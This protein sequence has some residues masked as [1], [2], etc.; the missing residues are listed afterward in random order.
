MNVRFTS[1]PTMAIP[2][3]HS[4]PLP[5]GLSD[6]KEIIVDGVAG[7][8]EGFSINLCDGPDLNSQTA[9]HFNPRFN[10][11]EVVRTHNAGGWGAEEKQGAF[12]F[13]RGSG[14]QVKIVVKDHAY[15]V[16][17]NNS[18]FCDFNHRVPKE[19]V[20][21]VFVTG[22]TSLSRVSFADQYAPVINNPPVPFTTA[23]P[24]G[25]YPGRMIFISGV[26][27][28]G[29]DRFSVNLVCGGDF[30]ACD[31]ALHMDNRLAYGNGNTVVRTHK[32]GGNW[33]AEESFQNFFPFSPNA[34]FEIMILAEPSGY[35]IAVNNQHFCEFA[36]RIQPV[37]R[38]DHV[39][40]RGDVRLTQVRFQ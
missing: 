36:H 9:F 23:I 25:M 24:G 8:G 21:Y 19:M 29:A 34:Q 39:H 18:F 40:V 22:D 13:F 14:Y 32:Q 35:K 4:A 12:P 10:Q 7:H 26:P 5:F 17:V 38:A 20:R 33:G 27:N 3:P 1:T 28:F 15:Q 6:G 37:Q 16:F 31:V 11:N 2:V 30:D